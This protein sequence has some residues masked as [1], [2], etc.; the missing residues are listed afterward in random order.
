MAV[1]AHWI[2]GVEVKTMTGLQKNMQLRS[3]LVGFLHIPGRHTGKHLAE[4]FLFILDRLDITEKVSS[5]SICLFAWL[6][7]FLQ[8][9]CITCDNASNNNTMMTHLQ[10]MLQKKKVKFHA[11]ENRIRYASG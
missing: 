5:G 11:V 8:I 7:I 3:D 1:T 6:L 4:C 9:G 10:A 2:E